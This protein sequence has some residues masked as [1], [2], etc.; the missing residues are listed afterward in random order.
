MRSL[1]ARVAVAAVVATAMAFIL[2]IAVFIGTFVLEFR[3]QA[4]WHNPGDVAA[5]ERPPATGDPA[6]E[7]WGPFWDGQMGSAGPPAFIRRLA[8]RLVLVNL[9]VLA[10]VGAVGLV[11]GGL[12]LRP[13]AAL[14]TA[15]E[16]VASTRDLAT[17]LPEGEGP[18]EV[19]ALAGS[20]NA[21]LER[22]QRSTAQI[23]ATL[24]ASRQFAADAGHE[25]R[26]PLTSMRA[27]LDVLARS[28]NLSADERRIMADVTREQ[29][30]LLALLDG[31]QRLARGDAAGAVPRERL[32]LADIVDAAVTNAATRHPDATITFEGPDDV[33]IAGWSDGLRLLIDN[34]LDNAVR[35]GRPDVRVA[36]TLTV[37]D[38]SAR[39]VVDDDGPGIPD[40]ERRQVFERFVRGS[41]TQAPGSGLGLALVAQQAAVHGGYARIDASP[42]GGARVLVDVPVAADGQAFGQRNR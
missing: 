2:S 18:E 26:T 30:R 32:D 23:E 22:L 39:I 4:P 29:H 14:Q 27:N 20:L 28:S 16:R 11:L 7:A 15:A 24:E 36:V 10:V 33:P 13:L 1:R 25:L 42:L 8:R 12:A 31:L 5:S 37:R 40:G 41:G 3:G 21:M 6:A 34:L 9:G 19:D 35:H 38:G 17:R